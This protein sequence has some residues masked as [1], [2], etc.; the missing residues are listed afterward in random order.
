MSY[1]IVFEVI[2]DRYSNLKMTDMHLMFGFV[3]CN[4][5]E[6]RRLY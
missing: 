4:A 6:A 1:K 3:M 5:S 2:M